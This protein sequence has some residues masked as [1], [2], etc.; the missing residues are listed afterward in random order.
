MKNIG[1]KYFFGQNNQDKI[2]YPYWVG[3]PSIMDSPYEDGMENHSIILTGFARGNY[4][5]LIN[6]FDKI[7]NHFKHTIAVNTSSGAVVVFALS[8][9]IP[10]IPTGDMELKRAEI[11]L[12][13]KYWA[14]T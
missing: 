5:T 3:E 4:I 14:T 12:T 8:D 1:V 7:K 6:E 9:C 11:K 2:T 13:V 10:N